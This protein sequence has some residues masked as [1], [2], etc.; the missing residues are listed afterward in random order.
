MLSSALRA[1][2]LPSPQA[3]IQQYSRMTCRA[4]KCSDLQSFKVFVSAN[5]LSCLGFPGAC[6]TPTALATAAGNLIVGAAGNQFD[7]ADIG[8]FAAAT[9]PVTPSVPE[10]GTCA[11]IATGLAALGFKRR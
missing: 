11:L 3:T 6:T 7:P 1:S 9:G 2:L 4:L 8:E 10:P 5:S